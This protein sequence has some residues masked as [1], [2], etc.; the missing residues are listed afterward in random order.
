M[1]TS[2]NLVKMWEFKANK[3]S[4][5]PIPSAAACAVVLLLAMHA[6]FMHVADHERAFSWNS[7]LCLHDGIDRMPSGGLVASLARYCILI[8]HLFLSAGAL[9]KV[10]ASCCN[11]SQYLCSCAHMS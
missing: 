2:S 5:S 11:S 3:V 1:G 7:H 10:V 8:R 9:L 6:F 4:H